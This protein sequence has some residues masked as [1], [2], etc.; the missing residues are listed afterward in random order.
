MILDPIDVLRL[1][2]VYRQDLTN[3]VKRSRRHGQTSTAAR[4]TAVRAFLAWY[5][6]AA[7]RHRIGRVRVRRQV[8]A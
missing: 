1:Q 5:P 7:I 4:S 6:V 3:Q 2:P 8:T